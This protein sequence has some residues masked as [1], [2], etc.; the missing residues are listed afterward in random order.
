MSAF[1]RRFYKIFRRPVKTAFRVRVD[2]AE[3][4]PSGGFILA[5]NHTSLTDVLVLS[6]AMGGR[7][8]RYMAK[9]ELFRIPLFGALLRALGAYSVNRGGSDVHSVK[10]A[11]SFI[12]NGE[13]LGIFPQGTRCPRV[14]PRQTEVKG[15]LGLIAYHTKADVLPAFID[16]VGR[17][18][19]IFRRNRVIFGELIKYEEL[20]LTG[21]GVKEYRAAARFVFDRICGLGSND[22]E[23]NE[24]KITSAENSEYNSGEAG[25]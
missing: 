23:F 25:E 21:G 20:G 19:R 17:R 1:Y 11:I 14:D 8:I 13:V 9:K 24:K 4:I 18:T 3:N 22:Q 7:Q 6:E 5:C 12:E 15:G 10:T 16:N 2:G